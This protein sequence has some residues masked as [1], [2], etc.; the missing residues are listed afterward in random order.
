MELFKRL[1]FTLLAL[2]A[3]VDLTLAVLMYRQVGILAPSLAVVVLCLVFSCYLFPALRDEEFSRR[4]FP[5]KWFR[6]PINE[7]AAFWITFAALVLIHLILTG[8]WV[9]LVYWYPD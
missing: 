9:R 1:A 3:L 6:G 2:H 7:P 8:L 4:W 5:G